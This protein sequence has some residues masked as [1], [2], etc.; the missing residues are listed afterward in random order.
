M[1]AAAAVS[2][3]ALTVL[4]R[5]ACTE[6]RARTLWVWHA[7]GVREEALQQEELGQELPIL[8]TNRTGCVGLVQH[9]RCQEL[10]ARVDGERRI[11]RRSSRC[12][13]LWAQRSEH[14]SDREVAGTL[15]RGRWTAAVGSSGHGAQTHRAAARRQPGAKLL[16]NTALDEGSSSSQRSRARE[17]DACRHG[18][19]RR[20]VRRAPRLRLPQGRAAR[21]PDQVRLR[22]RLRRLPSPAQ[23]ACSTHLPPQPCQPS[24]GLARSFRLDLL[25]LPNPHQGVQGGHQGDQREHACRLPLAAGHPDPTP[26][27]D[28]SPIPKPKPR[29]KP[30]PKPK[31]IS[32]PASS[33]CRH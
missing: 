30:R 18:C 32:L 26:S 23:P 33:R 1:A 6:R 19:G 20:A 11:A 16:P 9:H 29:P 10:E 7:A 24:L 5:V 15:A 17:R 12:Q 22:L 14:R 21:Q 8:D 25:P 13:L 27:P 3:G 28:P 4:P 2:Q 31:P